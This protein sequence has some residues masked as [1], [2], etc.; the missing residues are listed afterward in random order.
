VSTALVSANLADA[1]VFTAP[2]PG[3][4][5]PE[6]KYP[7]LSVAEDRGV[8]LA[9]SG[10]LFEADL[11]AAR[12]GVP[13]DR[14]LRPAELVLL[15]YQRLGDRWVHALRGHFA[16]IVDDRQNARITAVRDPMGLH[17]LFTA[18]GSAGLLF[19]W[20][21][22]ALLAQPGV[23]RDLNRIMLAEH[24]VHRWSNPRE[25]Y[26]AAIERVPPGHILQ[27]D[28]S[29]TSVRRYW[30]PASGAG[31]DWVKDDA[32]E[33]F[34]D[35]LNRAVTRCLSQGRTGI[36]LSGG[37]DSISIAAVSVD[38]ASKLG[39][40]LPRALSLGFPDPECNEELVQ[41][42]AACAL[43]IEQ[44][45]VGFGEA[46][47]ER[48]LLI[49]ALE[50][51]ASWPAPMM[52][53]W[54]PAYSHLAM[55]GASQGCRV[56]LTG[57]GGDEWLAVTP[58]VAADMLRQGRLGDLARFVGTTRRSYKV[59]QLQAM[60]S[61][62]WTFGMRPTLGML[63]NRV[64]PDRWQAR[65]HRRIVASTPPWVAPD[66]ELRRQVDERASNVLGDSEPFRGSFYEQQ[67]R[68]ALE[69]PLNAMEAEEYF[70]QGRRLGVRIVHPYWD[71]DL[72]D[73]LYRTPPHILSQGG[74][75]KGLVRATIARRFP[76]LGF[77]R[78]KKVH[79]T[80]FYWRTMQAEGPAAWASLG[81]AATLASLGVLDAKLHATT[82]AELFAGQRPHESYRIWNTLHLEGWARPRA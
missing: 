65:R 81:S 17:P 16:V 33:R 9:F 38:E 3:T 5:L 29:G 74:R 41:R 77:E 28:R 35:A 58:Y 59:T 75:A 22:D 52:N 19:S 53:L 48:G 55:R 54:N 72:V 15:A 64:A 66:P 6:T 4:P 73:L 18:R 67:M 14:A 27:S 56:I 34:N 31:I 11:L 78:Q 36:F 40:P 68:T 82:M 47:G 13:Q 24:L 57:S 60:K 7:Q 39:Q 76:N 23:S 71:S 21:T 43:G 50:M 30:D 49:P 12:V 79:A 32:L 45:Y 44:D 37:F 63:I 80:S 20:S 1:W 51:A 10:T 42:G 62:M 70:E 46:V 8:S 26:F 25:T 69:H 2:S 61:V